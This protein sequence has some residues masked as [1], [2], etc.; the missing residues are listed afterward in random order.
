ML[1]FHIFSFR[2][3]LGF[4]AEPDSQ[5]VCTRAVRCWSTRWAIQQV[6]CGS[7]GTISVGNR[8]PN[9]Q[10]RP[11]ITN[12]LTSN[13]Q[14]L[15]LERSTQVLGR[16]LS[17]NPAWLM[18]MHVRLVITSILTAVIRWRPA[19]KLPSYFTC[20]STMLASV[21]PIHAVWF[22]RGPPRSCAPSCCTDLKVGRWEGAKGV[23][24]QG[25]RQL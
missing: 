11:G 10:T 8:F 24:V 20:S 21:P 22:S 4:C 9:R 18:P 16:Q 3:D 23:A 15:K 17:T 12:P 19:G 7:R 1:V 13:A 5:L 2:F 25:L 14:L 6:Q